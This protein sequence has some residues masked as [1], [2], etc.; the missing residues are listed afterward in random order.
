M[1]IIESHNILIALEVLITHQNQNSLLMKCQIDNTV[2][3]G[4][5]LTGG[6]KSRAITREVN[7][8]TQSSDISEEEIRESGRSFQTSV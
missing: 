2:P 5:C 3:G 1:F 4:C 7:L 6:D 8:D